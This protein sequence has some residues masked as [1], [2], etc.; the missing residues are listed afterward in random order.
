M[1]GCARTDLDVAQRSNAS[2]VL[3]DVM[4]DAAGCAE[5]IRPAAPA[6]AAAAQVQ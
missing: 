2:R 1:R 6:V 5:C 3:V 4:G